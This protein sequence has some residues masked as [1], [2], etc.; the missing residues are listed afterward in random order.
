MFA[1]KNDIPVPAF[2]SIGRPSTIYPFADLMVGDSFFV[3]INTD[4][5][6]T[7]KQILNRTRAS[8]QRWKKVTESKAVKLRIMPFA[9]PD[10][11]KEAVGV[12]RVA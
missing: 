9:D 4:K 3:P 11:G 6:E 2:T 5:Q 12:W 8:A 1:I 10:T 7:V